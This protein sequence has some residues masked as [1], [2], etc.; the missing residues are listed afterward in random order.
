MRLVLIHFFLFLFTALTDHSATCSEKI[1]GL[2]EAAL[3]EIEKESEK[4]GNSN[5]N[6]YGLHN[7]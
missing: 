2:H 7:L 4:N 5:N 3:E 1:V 6:G